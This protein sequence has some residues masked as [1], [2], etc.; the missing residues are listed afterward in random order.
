M[1]ALLTRMSSWPKASSVVAMSRSQADF[2]GDVGGDELGLADSLG[3][4]GDGRVA[5]VL[6]GV[7]DDDGCAFG[8]EELGGGGAH[9]AAGA[10]DDRD[11]ALE[12]H[13]V[14]LTRRDG[15]LILA[16]RDSRGEAPGGGEPPGSRAL[17]AGYWGRVA[18]LELVEAVVL[19]AVG[20]QRLV[21]AFFDDLAVVEDDDAV[22][23]ADGVEAVSDHD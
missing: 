12:T 23:R 17:A 20:E 18:I 21:G 6:E 11:F 10:S 14:L 8:R 9:A 5:A 13:G 2:V 19:A 4:L 3:D 15:R 16:G 7:G 1:P 22:H